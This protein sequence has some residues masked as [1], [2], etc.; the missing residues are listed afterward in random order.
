MRTVCADKPNQEASNPVPSQCVARLSGLLG[1]SVPTS[2][3]WLFPAHVLPYHF[4]LLPSTGSHLAHGV[5]PHT[6]SRNQPLSTLPWAEVAAGA[7]PGASGRCPTL[8]LPRLAQVNYCEADQETATC[9]V[10]T[11]VDEGDVKGRFQVGTRGTSG[12][13]R[14]RGS[15]TRTGMPEPSL[16]MCL[17]V[18]NSEPRT[19]QIPISLFL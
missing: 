8:Y 3:F 13:G 6:L 14:V 7:A 18:L 19:L 9:N 11:G 12:Q 4:L 15:L 2:C 16:W 5:C 17:K 1:S 10:R